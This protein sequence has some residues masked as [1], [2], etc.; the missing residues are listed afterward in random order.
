MTIRQ[1]YKKIPPEKRLCHICGKPV[2][3]NIDLLDGEI[4]HHGC[5][6][7]VGTKPTHRCLD[8]YSLLT[9]NKIV[10]TQFEP[11]GPVTLTCGLC[12]SSNLQ[13]LKRK[14]GGFSV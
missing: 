5:L 6:N 11:D 8:C 3:R 7:K 1:L 12:G 2:L 10:R 9:R 13:P 14:R 4:V